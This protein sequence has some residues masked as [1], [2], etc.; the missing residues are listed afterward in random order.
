MAVERWRSGV[1][2]TRAAS[3]RNR[4]TMNAVPDVYPG[5]LIWRYRPGLRDTN[6]KTENEERGREGRERG[7]QGEI[8]KER[9]K[10]RGRGA[11]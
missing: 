1:V 5:L 4:W 6:S 7:G 10:E 9:G 3:T 2:I 11:E 8:E